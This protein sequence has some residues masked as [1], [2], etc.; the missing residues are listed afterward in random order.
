M[1]G[2]Q[3][4][5]VRS[6]S[7]RSRVC[8]MQKHQRILRMQLQERIWR[9]WIWLS[10]KLLVINDLGIYCVVNKLDPFIRKYSNS[11]SEYIRMLMNAQVTMAG[12]IHMPTAWT[13]QEGFAVSVIL[14]IQETGSTAQIL[15]SV[16]MN[17]TCARMAPVPTSKDR[18]HAT[19]KKDSHIRQ[20][21]TVRY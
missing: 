14:G 13:L 20:K 1:H 16:L 11:F 12:V 9:G 10:C 15:M 17:P 8:R 21:S 5:H 18:S 4:M 7:L 3:R 19:V 6:S 2:W